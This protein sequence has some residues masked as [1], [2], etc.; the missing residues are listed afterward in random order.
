MADKFEFYDVKTKSKVTVPKD[1]VKKI[2]IAKK[3]GS[4]QAALRGTTED[5]RA[6]TKFVKKS[7]WDSYDLPKG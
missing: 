2:M 1:R 7:D 3:N 4:S 5:G 6:L